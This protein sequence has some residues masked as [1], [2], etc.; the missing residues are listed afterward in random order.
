MTYNH[1]DL[2]HTHMAVIITYQPLGDS[3]KGYITSCQLSLNFSSAE[4]GFLSG[5]LQMQICAQ[6]HRHRGLSGCQ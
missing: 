4:R 2:A 1:S 3:A 6:E 5:D